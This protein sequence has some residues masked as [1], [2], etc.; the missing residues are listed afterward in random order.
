MDSA[1]MKS[2]T[3]VESVSCKSFASQT[4]LLSPHILCGDVR[5]I[6]IRRN[7]E[8]FPHQ[9]EHQKMRAF[10]PW[11]PNVPK[12]PEPTPV[13]STFSRGVMLHTVVYA[14]H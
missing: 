13:Q 14:S 8:S 11:Y 5:V 4:Y 3:V 1:T 9:K 2:E 12:F 7:R 10:R 6:N